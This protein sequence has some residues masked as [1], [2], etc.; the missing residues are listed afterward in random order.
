MNW[1]VF[2]A[3]IYDRHLDLVV[4][5]VQNSNSSYVE[6][7]TSDNLSYFNVPFTE[8]SLGNYNPIEKDKPLKERKYRYEVAI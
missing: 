4:E 8:F 3:H 6:L 1:T 2:N 5:Q 7:Y